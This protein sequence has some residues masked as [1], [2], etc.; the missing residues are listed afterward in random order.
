MRHRGRSLCAALGAGLLLL[1]CAASPAAAACDEY[2]PAAPINSARITLTAGDAADESGDELRSFVATGS[3]GRVEARVLS[4][5]P[6]GIVR[7]VSATPQVSRFSPLYGERLKGVAIV[8]RLKGRTP[9]AAVVLDV[10]QVCAQYF[11]NTFLYY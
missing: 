7:T 11:R 5:T 1:G 8:V 6:S 10:R 2:D 9:R 4:A 3:L